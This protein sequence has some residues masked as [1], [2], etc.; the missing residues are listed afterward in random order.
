MFE[1][2][3]ERARRVLFFARY[4]ATRIGGDAIDTEHLLLG[5]VREGKG[6][7]ARILAQSTISLESIRG[8]RRRAAGSD[9]RHAVSEARR[10][11]ATR[12]RSTVSFARR[13]A[14]PVR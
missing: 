11:A 3:T 10:P 6:L 4:E 13:P 2:F 9:E 12:R 8:D 14:R 5:L 7:T 1:R